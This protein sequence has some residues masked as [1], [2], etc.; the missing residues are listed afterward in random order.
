MFCKSRMLRTVKQGNDVKNEVCS[1]R[2]SEKE[3][4]QILKYRVGRNRDKTQK[5]EWERA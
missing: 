1:D 4:K 2:G 3:K 5:K